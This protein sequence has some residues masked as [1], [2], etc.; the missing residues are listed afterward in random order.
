[1]NSGMKI[2]IVD[3]ESVNLMLLEVIVRQEGYDPRIFDNPFDALEYLEGNEADL[4]M[5]DFNMPGLDGIG[6]LE[7]AK[8]LQPKIKSIM[9]TGNE[10]E[11]VREQAFAKGVNDFL[12]KPYSQTEVKLRIKN[13]HILRIE[14]RSREALREREHE[15]LR[16]LSRT[17]EYKDPETGSH[18]ARV[19][20]YSK[21]LARLC[22]LDE[23]E[24]ELI[25]YAAP[26]HD[27][28]KVGIEDAVLLKP[29]KLDE[30][31]FERMKAHSD[32]GY[33][34]LADAQ[35]PYLA[36]GA[37]IARSH[38]EKYNGTGYPYGLKGEEIPLYGRIVAIADVFDALTSIR[39]YKKAWSF[40][41]AMALIVREKGEHFDPVLVDLFVQSEA[42][43]REIFV[44]FGAE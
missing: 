39:P 18:I 37:V 38:H 10:E 41:E 6:L 14:E 44:R 31:E 1:M 20:H 22:G 35:N 43:I 15:A 7:K 17:A 13:I 27:I 23:E 19:A 28:G 33:E 4:L 16:I 8:E 3:D 11:S 40:E 34:I 2:V 42:E 26:L 29:G 5:T 9:I 24:Q 36:A 21:M 25:F 12:N 30:A 32:V